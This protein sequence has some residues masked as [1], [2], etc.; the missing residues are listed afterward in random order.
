MLRL[1]YLST[2]LLRRLGSPAHAQKKPEGKKDLAE[3]PLQPL[4]ACSKRLYWDTWVPLRMLRT[5]LREPGS[6]CACSEDI[7][8][9]GSPFCTSPATIPAHAQNS[10]GRTPGSVYACSAEGEL[11]LSLGAC[12]EQPRG[13]GAWIAVRM[14]RVKRRLQ[15]E[16]GVLFVPHTS[17]ADG[18]RCLS[19]GEK[20]YHCN[21][22]GCGWKFAR[23]D[24]LTRHY[25]KH[26]GHRP[27]PCPLC[28]RAFS[29]S[30]HLALHMKRH[31]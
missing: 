31:L 1:T 9:R 19:S 28:D 29:R 13:G 27:F 14:L 2:A 15:R 3:G 8:G 24:E 26:T 11:G 10:F 6:L 30:D 20:P 4:C 17:G 21:W 23:S 5:L 18:S 16:R 22:E 12:S 25:R 7:R